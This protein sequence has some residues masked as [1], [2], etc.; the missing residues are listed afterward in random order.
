[1]FDWFHDRMTHRI[2][3][4]FEGRLRPALERGLRRHLKSCSSCR[5]VNDTYLGAEAANGRSLIRQRDR[6]ERAIFGRPARSWPKVAA[7][8]AA[9]ALLAFFVVYSPSEPDWR[10]KAV[11]G[12]PDPSQWV[13]IRVYQR[14][15]DKLLRPVDEEIVASKG[16]AFSYSNRSEGQYNRLMVFGLDD[17]Y[18]VYWFYPAWTEPSENPSAIPVKMGASAEEL[19]DEI[20]HDYQGNNLRIFALF[21]KESLAVKQ[22]EAAVHNMARTPI[23]TLER[24]P[25]AGTGQHTILVKVV[26][27]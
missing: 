10:A 19:P 2:V 16:L 20:H 1:M 13:S 14:N 23:Q 17:N 22:V 21:S 5:A 8:V 18:R 3:L 24:I 6:L 12:N 27:Q 4:H 26:A 11:G 15:K 25:V 9:T 7:A